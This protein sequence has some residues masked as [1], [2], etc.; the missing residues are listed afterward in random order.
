MKKSL[1]FVLAAMFVGIA[2]I[3]SLYL[4]PSKQE[5]ALTSYKDKEYRGALDLYEQEYKNGRVTLDTAMHLVGVYLQY[6]EVEKAI[7]VMEA[8]VKRNPNHLD[9]RRELGK[10]YQYG[11]RPE[12]YL[13]NLEKINAIA[14][15]D[16]FQ[17][18]LSSS[19]KVSQD[20]DK[21][22]PLMLD[23]LMKEGKGSPQEF[24][25]LVRM[26]AAGKRYDE[27][28][29][30]LAAFRERFPEKMEFSDH[31][32][33]LRLYADT[34]KPD[35][36]KSYA[37]SLQ[38][39]KLSSDEIARV[40]NILLYRVNPQAAMEF[41]EHYKSEIDASPALLS[42][43]IVILM[44]T[45]GEQEAYAMMQ[46]RYEEEALPV[47][48]YD[49]LFTLASTFGNDALVAE[50]REKIDYASLDESEILSLIDLS[51]TRKDDALFAKLSDRAEVLAEESGDFYL[52]SVLMVVSNDK[53]ANARIAGVMREEQSF[54][55]RLQ[56]ALLCA[57]KGFSE[58]VNNFSETLPPVE[59]L[60]DNEVMAVAEVMR[61]TKQT[62]A[63]YAYLSRAREARDN[64]ALDMA[65]F[66]LAAIH[67][68]TE[69]IST[70][71]SEKGE[72]LTDTALRDGYYLSMDHGKTDTATKI[73]EYLYEK[74]K[75]EGNRQLIAQAYL[76]GGRYEEVLPM[77][78]EQRDASVQ[79]SDD[80]LFVLAKLAKN[81]PTYGKELGDY[82]VNILNQS[83]DKKRRMAIIYAL[84]EGGQQG[85]VM[86]YV[87]DLALSN[88][89]E[90]ASLYSGYMRKSGGQSAVNQ[91]WMDVLAQHPEDRALRS[92]VAY[93]LLSQGQTDAATGLFK[94]LAVN[95]APDS[96]AVA[97]LMYL[98][99]PIAPAEGVQWLSD[100]ANA[101]K[102]EA[103]RAAWLR[104]LADNVTDDGL[105]AQASNF[106]ELLNTVAVEDRYLEAVRRRTEAKQLPVVMRSYL[107][108]RIEAA[109]DAETLTR[110]GEMAQ[111]NRLHDLSNVA[112]ER[113]LQVAPNNPALLARL[114]S[115]AYGEADYSRAEELL[116]HYFTLNVPN[117][118]LS[119]AAEAHRPHFYYAELMRR[120]RK[121]V[122]AHQ[123]YKAVIVNGEKSQD[124]EIQS[125]VARSYAYSGQGK[126]AKEMY[127]SLI[128]ANP[129]N[130]QLRADYSA[131]LVELRERDVAEGSL[132]AWQKPLTAAGGE[133]IPLSISA[134]GAA[135]Y[136][137][138]DEETGIMLKH[139]DGQ[140]SLALPDLRQ[141][142]W[143]SYARGGR[144]ETLL[145]ASSG[146]R[147]Q[148]MGGDNGTTWLHPVEV[149]NG[150]QAALDEEFAIQNE[151]IRARLEVE[152]GKAY[153]SSKRVR[154]LAEKHPEN[155]Q[156]LGFS[157]NV[158]NFIGNWPYA[159]KLINKAHTLQPNNEDIVALQRG[160]EREHASSVYLDGEWRTLGESD[161]F[162]S[163]AGGTYD[164][165]ENVQIGL[166]VQNNS[167][168]SEPV[169]LSDGTQ[170]EFSKDRQRGEV[171]VRYFDD[172]GAQS[173]VSLFGNNDT[174]GVGAYHSF[175]NRLGFTNLGI[176]YHRPNWDFVEGV[177]EDA[178]RDRIEIGHRYSPNDKTIVTG[179]LG[180]NNYNTKNGDGLASSVS[181]AGSVSR[182]VNEYPYV[183]V[184]YGLDAEY[185]MSDKTGVDAAGTEFQRFPFDSREVHS[186]NVL[187]NHEFNE[188]TMAE[189]LAS[190][191]YDRMSGDSGPTVEGRVT[192]YL[193]D[194]L[195]VQGRAGYGFRGGASSGEASN[196][197][198]RLQYRY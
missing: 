84:V 47:K 130:R 21:N 181:V 56:L 60:T 128:Q 58:C 83:V 16:E 93:D 191:G 7:E 162:I 34:E 114:A 69:V 121:D 27:A 131:M 124:A 19:Y 30:A 179:E 139:P 113:A 155:P 167:V 125:M 149:A 183:A 136:R 153:A 97:E 46:T 57:R 59:T 156:V 65:W 55:R 99:S 10:L 115:S 66:P 110:Y 78:R 119:S 193:D 165:N 123:H 32:L 88:P 72:S 71:L 144:G 74:D 48:L 17:K 172:E 8:Y 36:V 70:Y 174:A 23:M 163:T 45:G 147:L 68:S 5:I 31:E 79:A 53:S 62:D 25:D 173:Q 26:L 50:L 148:M 77:L 120:Q 4:I 135:G 92:Q 138:V 61:N 161:M 106:P 28:L 141:Y 104:L 140:E 103:E 9:A 152:T 198:V 44:N 86:P 63:A 29:A 87:R 195:S 20:T 151:L 107:T 11:Q 196:A 176:E 150:Q 40:S 133:L 94:E 154:A 177:L 145:V 185:E 67:D 168:D 188:D 180:V 37:A 15:S 1:F 98:W 43:Y 101:A 127:R 2:I 33:T 137:L 142:R 143:L 170:G 192:H 14:S 158:E 157:A 134:T 118:S 108:P 85:R 166:E 96:K 89:K 49:E 160:I 159:R 41:I 95:Q 22:I 112:Y 6:A 3:G 189:G 109:Q 18:T 82:G 102:S 42:Q 35:Q 111:A 116:N 194:R 73:A 164:V 39:V 184:G 91:F 64:P 13:R 76:K 122:D 105:I 24:R 54:S 38:G 197:G 90:W 51:Q 52:K 187:G 178:T 171:F 75:T 100:R 81:N 175:V 132:P 190:Y 146:Y 129:G 126:K 186:L 80:Y 169:R 182:R 117:G 12:D